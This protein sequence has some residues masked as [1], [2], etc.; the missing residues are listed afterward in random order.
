[1]SIP[2]GIFPDELRLT[3]VIPLFKS[4]DIMLTNNCRPVSILPLFSKVL[5]KLMYASLL[6]ILKNISSYICINLVLREYQGTDIA[7]TMLTN[8]LL[9]AF[10]EEDIVR[11][12]FLDL[13]K[14]L[15]KAYKITQTC[16]QRACL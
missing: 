12:F 4:G 16:Y 15:N 1:M 7:L 2:N 3:K 9:S 13:K 8:T 11:G 10:D 6:S 5:K 14:A